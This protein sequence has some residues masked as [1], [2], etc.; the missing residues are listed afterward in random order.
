MTT[1]LSLNR[2]GKVIGERH[3]GQLIIDG[4]GEFDGLTWLDDADNIIRLSEG[5]FGIVNNTE[6]FIFN[7]A[8]YRAPITNVIDRSSG[9]RLGGREVMPTRLITPDYLEL[10]GL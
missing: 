6:Y 2:T 4:V 9:Y 7:E 8:L 3:N 5:H 10:L 1:V